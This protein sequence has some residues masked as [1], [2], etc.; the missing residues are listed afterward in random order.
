[1]AIRKLIQISNESFNVVE[2]PDMD[3][4]Y[5]KHMTARQNS[6]RAIN[7]AKLQLSQEGFFDFL[8][9]EVKKEE[10]NL[11][12]IE[13]LKKHL[14]K[15][16]TKQENSSS[17]VSLK[18]NYFKK[19]GSFEA[20]KKALQCFN[21][22]C[23]EVDKSFEEKK[24]QL[25]G[26][27]NIIE[28]YMSKKDDAGQ[29]LKMY[30]SWESKQ[31]IDTEE[32]SVK[33]FK[34]SVE[35]KSTST[36]DLYQDHQASF[37]VYNLR[38]KKL[39]IVDT[40]E[41]VFYSMGLYIFDALRGFYFQTEV[42]EAEQVTVSSDE[43][44]ALVGLL[45][46]STEK[47]IDLV[48]KWGSASKKGYYPEINKIYEI[49]Q[50]EDFDHDDKVEHEIYTITQD[51]YEGYHNTLIHSIEDEVLSVFNGLLKDLS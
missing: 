31:K 27:V 35:F 20:I 30:K 1:M 47:V 39:G 32:F 25:S 9:K 10:E 24:K 44:H 48:E 37:V 4:T 17:S 33:K 29:I 41:D 8:K 50:R 49:T 38:D 16:Q 26:C 43:A 34:E 21:K 46:E 28:A 14:E 19:Q 6:K 12:G 36:V 7:V 11:N 15:A 40:L 5:M 18:H 22:L 23:D 45:I 42:S 2:L 13:T 51:N 3:L